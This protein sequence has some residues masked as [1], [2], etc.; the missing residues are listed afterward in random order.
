MEEMHM[1][2]SCKRQHEKSMVPM[3]LN[4]N[5]ENLNTSLR[6]IESA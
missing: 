4:S 1:G 3:E 2:R 5:L 6:I